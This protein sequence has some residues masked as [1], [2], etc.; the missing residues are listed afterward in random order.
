MSA[1]SPVCWDARLTP[2]ASLALIIEL[3]EEI[4]DTFHCSYSATVRH[5]S[6]VS[7]KC[8]LSP[9]M[10]W[11]ALKI[12]LGFDISMGQ[13]LESGSSEVLEERDEVLA[14]GNGSRRLE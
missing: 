4:D 3:S 5:Y 2:Y 6:D 13:F 8:F 11:V 14:S 10:G 12:A 7:S 9:V 1:R